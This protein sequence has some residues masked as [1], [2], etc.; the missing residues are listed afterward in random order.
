MEGHPLN[1]ILYLVEIIE[2]IIEPTL[3]PEMTR[4]RSPC[5]NKV[6]TTPI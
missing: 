4:G 5:S 1:N 3:D 6:F 2:A